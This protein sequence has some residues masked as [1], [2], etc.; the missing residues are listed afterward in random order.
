MRLEN[1]HYTFPTHFLLLRLREHFRPLGVAVGLVHQLQHV[2]VQTVT[3][4]GEAVD[5]DLVRTRCVCEKGDTY[6]LAN[7]E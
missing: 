3:V 4:V 5:H 7:I 6:N 1:L 2:L